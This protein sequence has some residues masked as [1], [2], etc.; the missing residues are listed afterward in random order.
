MRAWGIFYDFTPAALVEAA[1][2]AK[3]A[4]RLAPMNPR[5]HIILARVHVYRLWYGVIAHDEAN[6]AMGLRLAESGI[7]LAPRDEW[8]HFCMAGALEMA[9][10]TEEAVAECRRAIEFNPNF[11]AGYAELGRNLAANGQP[12]E[13]IEACR[14]ALR[15]NPRDPSN[16]ERHSS[17]AISHFVAGDDEAAT[18]EAR[19]AA[20]ARPELPE[21]LI[22]L[23]AAASAQGK[24]EEAQSAVEQCLARWPDIRLGNIMPIYIPEFTRSADRGRLLEMLRK[25]GLAE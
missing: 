4:I 24:I 22:I 13:A 15:L 21:P 11:S 14:M 25:A 1:E 9:G 3:Q 2:L 23:A 18:R 16:W 6:V 12:Q 7:R 20:Q 5:A 17:L 10:R 19:I 8:A